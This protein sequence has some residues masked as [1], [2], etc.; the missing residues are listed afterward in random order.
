MDFTRRATLAAGGSL[1]IA[2]NLAQVRLRSSQFRALP[3][4]GSRGPAA[5][6]ADQTGS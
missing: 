2:P 4:S 1:L 6:K 3:Y 5:C